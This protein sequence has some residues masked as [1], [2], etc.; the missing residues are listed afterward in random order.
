MKILY[1]LLYI[2]MVM[3]TSLNA[4]SLD[5]ITARNMMRETSDLI[6]AAKANKEA[7]KERVKSLRTLWGPTISAQAVEVW[8][9]THVDIDKSISTPLGSMPVKID[10]YKNFSGPRAMLTG[11]WPLFTGGKIRAEQKAS[12]SAFLEAESKEKVVNLEQDIKL[13]SCYFG[14]QLALTI[15]RVRKEMFQQQ[16]REVSRANEFEKEGMI[17][18][19]ERMSVDV[20]CD[21]S[22][23]EWL[24]AK[25][26]VRIARIELGNLLRNENFGAPSTPLFVIKHSLKSNKNWVNET[27]TN[28]P[29]I[30]VMEA[31]VKKSEAGVDAAK[32]NFFPDIFAFG[33]YS[34]IRHYQTMIEPAWMAGIGINFTLWDARG[35]REGYKSAKSIAREAKALHNNMINQVKTD[36]EVAWQNTNNAIERYQLTDG[37]IALAKE[38]LLLKTRGFEEGLNTALEMTNARTELA[39]AQVARK[40][41]AY[42]FVINYAILH[43]ISG[44]MDKFIKELSRKDIIVED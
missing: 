30:E 43:A 25:D 31:Q 3:T 44:N 40:I 26:S 37:N 15:E 1:A 5:F 12:Q 27:I 36:I 14:L 33:Q 13:I 18:R 10:E 24:K 42:E 32:G 6:A 38:N 11:T 21:K 34:F 17:S 35:R 2:V 39:E 4:K 16:R 9:E 29:Q 19:V 23:R 22:E 41:A 7:S 8:G 20:A 28:N